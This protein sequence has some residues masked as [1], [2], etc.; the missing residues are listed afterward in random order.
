LGRRLV[1]HDENGAAGGARILLV[2]DNE[3]AAES[4]KILLEL[5]GHRVCVVH[6]GAAGVEAAR[7]SAPDVM[8][9]DIG[10]PGMD[11]YEVA[12]LVRAENGLEHVLMVALT[13]YGRD[14]DRQQALAAGFDH[15]LV[16]PVNPDALLALVAQRPPA[17]K[18]GTQQ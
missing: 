1:K 7:A 18:A 13:G 3:D 11:G 15:H 9:V 16:K 4:L 14:E 10:L 5:V 17:A 6:D 8:L 2:E 12:K